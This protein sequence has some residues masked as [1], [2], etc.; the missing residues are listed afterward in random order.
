M[1]GSEEN[2]RA[3]PG[4][5]YPSI[6]KMSNCMASSEI[7]DNKLGACVIEESRLVLQV[8]GLIRLFQPIHPK[9]RVLLRTLFLFRV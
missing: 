6:Q 3:M 2:I 5:L 1:A 4:G 7:K 9:Q 8:P